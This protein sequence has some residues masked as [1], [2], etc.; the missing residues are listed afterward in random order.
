MTQP[1]VSLG[2][3][4]GGAPRA[5]AARPLRPP[6]RADR[7][8]AAPLPERPADAPREEQLLEDVASA[9]DGVLAGTLT[10]GASTGPG[11]TSCRSSVRVPAPP[12]GPGHRALDLRHV[13]GHRPRRR[14]RARA[15]DRRRGAPPPVAALRAAGAGRDRARRPSE[16]RPRRRDLRRRPAE[17]DA[18]RHAGGRRRASGGGRGAAPG[19]APRSGARVEARARAPRIGE[20]R[21]GRRVRRRL[22]L[23]HR[24]RRRAGRGTLAAARVSGIEPTRQIYVVRAKGRKPSRAAA[25]FLDFAAEQAA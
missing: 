7:G 11:R 8:R 13:R 4:A 5:A 15:R 17:R 18:R 24:D 20:E 10:L 9:D 14:P 6:R 1:A 16:P 22:H 2:A 19:R 21:G 25:A 12:R 23:A 3:G